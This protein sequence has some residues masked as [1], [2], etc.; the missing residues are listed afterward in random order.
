MIENIERVA[1]LIGKIT[2]FS[3]SCPCRVGP[4]SPSR[5]GRVE[6]SPRGLDSSITQRWQSRGLERGVSLLGFEV[7]S[8]DG[9]AE[10]QHKQAKNE[11]K[12]EIDT[13]QKC[14]G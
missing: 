5:D 14:F 4:G 7:D 12:I 8:A 13:L 3:R 6:P 11:E 9:G 1:I 2:R 10:G